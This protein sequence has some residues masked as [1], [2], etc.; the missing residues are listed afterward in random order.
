MVR[1][2]MTEPYYQD[3]HVTIYHADCR[4]MLPNITVDHVITDP[5][6]SERTHAGHD[7]SVNGRIGKSKDSSNRNE[8]G[9]GY[10]SKSDI[11]ELSRLISNSCNGWIVWMTDH[12]LAPHI[13]VSLIEQKRYVFAPLPYVAPGSSVRLSGDGPSSWTIWIIVSRTT[14]QSKWGTL[15]G[16]YISGKGWNSERCHMGGKPL[17]LM[18]AIIGDYS[19]PGET[20]LDP[21]MGSGTT[22]RAAKDLGRKAIGIEIEEKYCEIAAKRMAQEVLF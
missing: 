21:F 2:S 15:R 12:I 6:Y 9:Y 4:E 16:A 14:A 7:A 19:R 11:F 5:P 22:L 17:R 10:L 18:S 20:I 1:N 3:D 13:E 8:I